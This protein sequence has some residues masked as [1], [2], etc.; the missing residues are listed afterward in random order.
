MRLHTRPEAE[1]VGRESLLGH[2]AYFPQGSELGRS[3]ISLSNHF[4]GGV[5]GG[6][7]S[8][9]VLWGKM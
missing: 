4:T 1:R 5:D 3:G 2:T 8:L 9:I 7:V 6:N